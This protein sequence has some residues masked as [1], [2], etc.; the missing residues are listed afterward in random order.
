MPM[1]S[2]PDK[3]LLRC[4]NALVKHGT[5]AATAKALGMNLNTLGSRITKARVRG[6]EPTTKSKVKGLSKEAKQAVEAVERLQSKAKACEELDLS[7]S[8]LRT[9]LGHAKKF[10]LEPNYDLDSKVLATY[11]KALDAYAVL[12]S[13]AKVAR[14]FNWESQS[15]KDRVQGAKRR[16]LTPQK[17]DIEAEEVVEEK[18]MDPTD[19]RV[20]TLEREVVMLKDQKMAL[21]SKIKTMHRENGIYQTL[22]DE[23][24]KITEPLSPLPSQIVKTRKVVHEE[25]LVMHLSDEHADQVVQSHRV[26]GFEEY[27]ISVAL[28]RAEKFVDRVIAIS[29]QT[30]S[31]YKFTELW[32]LAYGDH[33][34]GEIHDATNHSQYRNAFDNTMAVGQMHALMIRDLAPYFPRIKILYLSGNHG[35]RSTKKDY[36]G[37]KDNWDY[38]VARTAEMLCA[39]IKNVEFLIPDSFSYTFEIG[40]YNFCCF[41]GDDIKSWNG[42]P[43]YGIERKTRRLSSLHSAQGRE[44]H[45]YVMGHFHQMSSITHPSGEIIINGSWK[46]TD[47]FAYEAL[48]VT[49][50]PSQLIHGMGDHGM[51]FRFPIYLKFDGDVK[52]PKR[53]TAPL[54]TLGHMEQMD[55]T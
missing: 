23:M 54:R 17:T 30:L 48:G 15:A 43:H 51:S 35:R 33:V 31:T 21:N 8:E 3:E 39:D 13:Y 29:Q 40:G 24:E 38:L 5:L 1:P 41:H 27:N 53:Y 20:L 45:Y 16:G 18:P 49:S 11:Q 4:V 22:A 50:K 25:P 36:H 55:K 6:I 10:G 44:I 12:G 46:A 9:Y 28:A 14:H 37:P 52:G 2:L 32:I 26:G 19:A 34:N 47:E 7:K 42:I